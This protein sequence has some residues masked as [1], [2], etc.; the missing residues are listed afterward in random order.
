[1]NRREWLLGCLASAAV[2]ATRP[3]EAAPP[4]DPGEATMVGRLSVVP[5]GSGPSEFDLRVLQQ[6]LLA[7]Y[8]FRV[9]VESRRPLP[10]AAFYPPRRR[11]RAER[12]LAWLRDQLVDA[13]QLV[14]GVTDVDISTEK[15]PFADF[16]IL[17][18]AEC[19]GRVSVVSTFRCRRTAQS[20]LHAALRFGKVAVHEFGHGLG[21]PHCDTLGCL[22]EDA[23]GTVGT[24]EREQDLCSVC[25][26]R[27]RERGI[28]AGPGLDWSSL[29]S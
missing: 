6:A 10:R 21:L 3:L 1:V 15:P 28:V 20:A 5:L 9:L 14:M 13:D 24:L 18:L 11:Y 17:G 22:L 12:L 4:T 8:P 7:H 23:G 16:G 25:R 2:L 26:G 29:T 27:L 19:P